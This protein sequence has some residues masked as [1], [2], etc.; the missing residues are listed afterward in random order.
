[1]GQPKPKLWRI[2]M[3]GLHLMHEE[4]FSAW[5]NLNS[6]EDFNSF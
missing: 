5:G 6:K 1:M 3:R 4:F 2:A